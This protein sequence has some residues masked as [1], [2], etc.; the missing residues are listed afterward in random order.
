VHEEYLGEK[1]GE[2]VHNGQIVEECRHEGGDSR[3]GG[4]LEQDFFIFYE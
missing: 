3:L 2:D 4:S 1:R